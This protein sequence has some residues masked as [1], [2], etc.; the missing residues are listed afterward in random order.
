VQRHG[1]LCYCVV[2]KCVG[3]AIM[4]A[5]LTAGSSLRLCSSVG[6]RSVYVERD[7][8]IVWTGLIWLRIKTRVGRL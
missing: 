5:S 4:Y 1:C 2:P 8:G 6:Y 7:D 3:V